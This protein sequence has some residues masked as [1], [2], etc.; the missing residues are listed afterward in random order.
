VKVQIIQSVIVKGKMLNP[1]SPD[2]PRITDLP[3]EQALGLIE[4]GVAVDPTVEEAEAQRDPAEVIAEKNEVIDKLQKELAEAEKALAAEV[5][6]GT[7][8]K[9]IIDDLKKAAKPKKK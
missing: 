9:K 4:I 5:K 2:N 8:Q 1:G 3:K 7:A 6:K